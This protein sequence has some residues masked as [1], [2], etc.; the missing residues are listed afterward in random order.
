MLLWFVIAL[1]FRWRFQFRVRSLLILVVAIAVPF[2][3]LAV[4]MKKAT[5]QKTAV[6]EIT[7]LGAF[8]VYDWQFDE[9][10]PVMLK[11]KPNARPKAPHR[12][13][14]LVRTISSLG[15]FS[16]TSTLLRSPTPT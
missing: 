3:W 10:T 5:K 16:Y 2:S 9:H 14:N 15:L 11:K 12:L 8:V 4:E 6:D 1:L 13:R 7:K